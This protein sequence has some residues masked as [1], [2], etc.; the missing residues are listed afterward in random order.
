MNFFSTSHVKNEDVES[1]LR[2]IERHAPV[3]MR[4]GAGKLEKDRAPRQ[5]I[6]PEQRERV[7]TLKREGKL[8][9]TEIARQVNLS[10][11]MAYKIWNLYLER[12]H[13]GTLRNPGHA[14][15]YRKP[16]QEAA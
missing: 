5:W 7:V 3:L 6:S 15:S 9:L 12:G 8:T 4:A 10:P 14:M 13:T 1:C 2:L 16:P 11:A